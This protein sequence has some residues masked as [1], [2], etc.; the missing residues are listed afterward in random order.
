VDVVAGLSQFQAPPADSGFGA[1]RPAHCPGATSE[2]FLSVFPDATPHQATSVVP[3]P[4][5][6][7]DDETFLQCRV[8]FEIELLD[9]ECT[10]AE[11]RDVSFIPS[12]LAT[13]GS[14]DG[15]LTTTSTRTYF[16]GTAQKEGVV[17]DYTLEAGCD[18]RS[19]LA[20]LETEFRTIWQSHRDQF[21]ATPTYTA[22]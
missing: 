7:A 14:H 2:H 3:E 9:A 4:Q 5:G 12:A 15:T 20:D 8:S 11:L 22:P 21:L 6:A 1:A 17:L 19:D 10:I 16:I 13:I 18:G